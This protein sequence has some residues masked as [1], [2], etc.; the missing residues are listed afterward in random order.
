KRTLQQVLKHMIEHCID[1][2]DAVSRVKTVEG[3]D[4]I[5]SE[6]DT[7]KYMK[8][9]IGSPKFPECFEKSSYSPPV[10]L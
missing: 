8:Y 9:I 7:R 10:C 4:G 2:A 5:K 6:S 3:M 1:I